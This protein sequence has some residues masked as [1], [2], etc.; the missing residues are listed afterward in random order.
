MLFAVILILILQKKTT[1]SENFNRIINDCGFKSL[2]NQPTRITAFSST[3]IDLCFS[4]MSKIEACVSVEDQIS[5]HK[6]IIITI[7]CELKNKSI[8]NTIIKSLNYTVQSLWN[9]IEEWFPQN[10]C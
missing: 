6:N 9:K 3:I 2:I 10:G 5:D 7:K 4:N 1:H 8:N